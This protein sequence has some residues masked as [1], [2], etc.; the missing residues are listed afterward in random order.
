MCQANRP[1]LAMGTS[2]LFGSFRS[3]ATWGRTVLFSSRVDQLA[4]RITEDH[5]RPV[6]GGEGPGADQMSVSQVAGSTWFLAFLCNHVFCRLQPASKNVCM[7]RVN[8][9]GWRIHQRVVYLCTNDASP[10]AIP[11]RCA[12]INGLALEFLHAPRRRPFPESDG[13]S[14]HP[15]GDIKSGAHQRAESLGMRGITFAWLV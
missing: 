14:S 11:F 6:T 9:P 5:D 8:I 10:F 2:N 1:G 13:F 12:F 7:R 3:A 4:T 15:S